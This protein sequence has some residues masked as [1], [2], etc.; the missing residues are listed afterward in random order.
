M[1]PNWSFQNQNKI[2]VRCKHCGAEYWIMRELW[3]PERAA[4]ALCGK[5]LLHGCFEGVPYDNI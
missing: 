2:H 3:T 4:L 5:C 1:N